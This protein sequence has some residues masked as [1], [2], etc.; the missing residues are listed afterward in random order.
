VIQCKK[1]SFKNSGSSTKSAIQRGDAC[2]VEVPDSIRQVFLDSD[3][4]FKKRALDSGK[5]LDP[6]GT[7]EKPH[8]SAHRESV[9]AMMKREGP[10]GAGC[11][12]M[13]RAFISEHSNY[14]AATDPKQLDKVRTIDV[15]NCGPE[16]PQSPGNLTDLVFVTG[17]KEVIAFDRVSKAFM[18]YTSETTEAGAV[19]TFHGSSHRMAEKNELSE[20]AQI[21]TH[22]CTQCHM[23]GGLVMKELRA[24]W[25]NWQTDRNFGN[26]QLLDLA[27]LVK[28]S[29]KEVPN[30][31]KEP[32]PPPDRNTPEFTHGLFTGQEVEKVTMQSQVLMNEIKINSILRGEP[33]RSPGNL[34]P[35][36]MTVEELLRPLFCETETIMATAL[37]ADDGTTAQMELP[38]D[39]F[40]NRLLIPTADK[41]VAELARIRP[42]SGA[43]ATIGDLPL[44]KFQSR[45]DMGS[46]PDAQDSQSFSTDN[47]RKFVP[48]VMNLTEWRKFKT[49]NGFFVPTSSLDGNKSSTGKFHFLIPARSFQ[50]DDF[51]SRAVA[52]GIFEEKLAQSALMVDFPNPLFSKRRCEVLKFAKGTGTTLVSDF[53]SNGKFDAAKLTQHVMK[54]VNQ[55][56]TSNPPSGG[57]ELLS[58]LKSTNAKL[59]GL[60]KDYFERCK[61]VQPAP[62]EI[63]KLIR[64]RRARWFPVEADEKVKR[65]QRFAVEDM[66]RERLVPSFEKIKANSGSFFGGDSF[67]EVGPH[68]LEAICLPDFPKNTGNL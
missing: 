47:S 2:G 67:R 34:S 18:Y 45:L 20:G 28:Q 54:G 3:D 29:N 38:L 12:D 11:K 63:W 44:I 55:M 25:L 43:T 24:P 61:S 7:N 57:V 33:I 49:N 60:V 46:G 41:N 31:R 22:P 64:S 30:S 21:S 8:K 66:V 59:S 42:A 23:N 68:L 65:E 14:F 37:T 58:N 51:V 15:F 26:S 10:N 36:S 6:M 17:S 27:E 32:L 39:L 9:A 40:I 53:V 62:E 1:R 13:G 16:V 56:P 4:H 48:P 5:C 35:G 50:D 19:F 52:A